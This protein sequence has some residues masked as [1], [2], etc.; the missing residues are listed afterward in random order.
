MATL[1][2]IKEGQLYLTEWQDAYV[3]RLGWAHED[4]YKEATKDPYVCYTVGWI[5]TK[6]NDIISL[7][8]TK[9]LNDD[10][11]DYQNV[12]AIPTGWIKKITKL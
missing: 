8:S 4:R 3:P 11:T 2:Q 5:I 1:K 9:G 12:I 10:G 7:G 6:N